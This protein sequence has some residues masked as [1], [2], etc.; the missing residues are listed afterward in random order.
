[1]A[2][3][4]QAYELRLGLSQ[5]VT[6]EPAAPKLRGPLSASPHTCFSHMYTPLTVKASGINVTLPFQLSVNAGSSSWISMM[7]TQTDTRP[8]FSVSLFNFCSSKAWN[9]TGIQDC[10]CCVILTHQIYGSLFLISELL[11]EL[12]RLVCFLHVIH[13]IAA[14]VLKVLKEHYPLR[15]A[16]VALSLSTAVK[17]YWLPS[18]RRRSDWAYMFLQ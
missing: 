7:G 2:G 5:L 8:L 15:P 1:M 4:W 17:W 10:S 3:S 14:V 11:S 9:Q 6:S 16:L 12:W 18:L 13:Y